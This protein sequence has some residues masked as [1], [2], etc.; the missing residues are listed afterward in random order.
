[1]PTTL[2]YGNYWD[3]Q[4]PECRVFDNGRFRNMND[5]ETNSYLAA[6]ETSSYH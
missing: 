5:N 1:M 4:N 3:G 2:G 6:W